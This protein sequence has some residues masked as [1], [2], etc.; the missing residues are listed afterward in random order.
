MELHCE[1]FWRKREKYSDWGDCADLSVSKDRYPCFKD[2]EPSAEGTVLYT[3]EDWEGMCA[4]V[5]WGF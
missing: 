3:S 5:I 2:Y 1:T 4:V